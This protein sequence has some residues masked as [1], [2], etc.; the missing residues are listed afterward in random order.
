MSG[1]SGKA[2]EFLYRA[3]Y[4]KKFNSCVL[5]LREKH[6]IP[7]EGFM[8]TDKFEKWL[9]SATKEFLLDC[10]KLILEYKF[11][12]NG[13]ALYANYIAIGEGD[14]EQYEGFNTD[15]LYILDPT[16]SIRTDEE[17]TL[18]EHKVPYVKVLIPIFTGQNEAVD[19]LRQNWDDIKA[20]LEKQ[21]GGPIKR[22][23]STKYKNRERRTA[24][25]NSKN[26][27]ELG[28]ED[29]VPK[30]IGIARIMTEEGM[31]VTSEQARSTPYRKKKL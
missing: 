11:P 6:S 2:A 4:D 22:I 15:M 17:D 10:Y 19:S 18:R 20:I 26:K 23:R 31:P 25:L 8:S 9:Q 27:L 16:R 13:L 29:H 14:W 1:N 24:Q 30:D 3:V 21:N 7:S 5:D 28:I 12:L